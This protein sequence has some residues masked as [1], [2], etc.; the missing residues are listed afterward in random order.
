MQLTIVR[1]DS[2]VIVDGQSQH[3]DLSGFDLPPN[4]HA[5]QWSLDRGHME[6]TNQPNDNLNTLPDWTTAVIEEHRRVTDQQQAEQDKQAKAAL[7][8]GNGTARQERRER[9]TL[10]RREREQTIINN[11]VR[12]NLT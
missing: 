4:L 5:L 6:Y 3:F 2:L 12:E 8:T 7:F 1:P 9:Q 11:L 10:A